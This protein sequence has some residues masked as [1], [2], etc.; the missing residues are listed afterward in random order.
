MLNTKEQG[1]HRRC[2]LYVVMTHGFVHQ[3]R[4]TS[5]VGRKSPDRETARTPFPS[6]RTCASLHPRSPLRP[7]CWNY[8]G[9]FAIRVARGSSGSRVKE[10]PFGNHSSEPSHHIRRDT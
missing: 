6:E 2:I 8:S 3:T 5:S 9:H 10:H 1:I 7:C 4:R